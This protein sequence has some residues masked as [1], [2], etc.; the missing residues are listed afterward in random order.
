VPRWKVRAAQ[1]RASLMV[2][3]SVQEGGANVI[4]EAIMAGLPVIASQIVGSVGLLGKDYP[5]YYPVGDT[6]ALGK[7]ILRAEQE[8]AYLKALR[9][10]CAA[11]VKLFDPA[12]ERRSWQ[13]LLKRIA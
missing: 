2:L 11:R 3:S 6:T 5:G 8:P 12:R 1:G 13:Q 10:H 7:L 4:S 9:R